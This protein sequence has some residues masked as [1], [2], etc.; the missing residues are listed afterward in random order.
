MGIEYWYERIEEISEE[1]FWEQRQL[2]NQVG[3]GC[4][5]KAA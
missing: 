3:L 1:L 4:S 5:F 2:G